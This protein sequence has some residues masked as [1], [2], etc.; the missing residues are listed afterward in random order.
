MLTAAS[1]YAKSLLLLP[2]F[3]IPSCQVY[4]SPRDHGLGPS[5][6]SSFFHDYSDRS[7]ESLKM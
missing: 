5:L 1:S 2:L 7:S 4:L 6:R 3:M